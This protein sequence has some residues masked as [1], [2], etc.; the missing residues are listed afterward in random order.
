MSISEF[1]VD[2]KNCVQSDEVIVGID[3]PFTDAVQ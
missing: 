3:V 1:F 2:D